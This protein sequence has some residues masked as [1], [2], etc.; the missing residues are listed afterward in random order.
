MVCAPIVACDYSVAVTA[1]FQLLYV[2]VMMEHSSRR[3]LHANVTRVVT[4]ELSRAGDSCGEAQNWRTRN[5]PRCVAT[6][7][8]R[9]ATR[10]SK[11]S[12]CMSST[13]FARAT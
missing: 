4:E 3:V 5:P 6:T 11:Q 1:T 12:A 2:F 8:R 13:A 9:P 10:F 7:S